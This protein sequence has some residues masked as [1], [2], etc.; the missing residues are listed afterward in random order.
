M[1]EEADGRACPFLCLSGPW[2][3]FSSQEEVFTPRQQHPQALVTGLTLDGPGMKGKVAKCPRA[4]LEP[5]FVDPLG[6]VHPELGLVVE[7]NE[8]TAVRPPGFIPQLV[9]S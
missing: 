1:D 8:G 5:R 4:H 7:R 2:Q 6:R 9:V 3:R